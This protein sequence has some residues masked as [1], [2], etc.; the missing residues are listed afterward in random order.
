MSDTKIKQ[1]ARAHEK[2]V[3][4]SEAM[5][6]TMEVLCD[7][8]EDQIEG[9]APEGYQLANRAALQD[10]RNA[11]A[12]YVHLRDNCMFCGNTGY[13]EAMSM[14]WTEAQFDEFACPNC[15]E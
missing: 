15:G 13:T 7:I 14:Q 1:A 4:A 6:A 11:L 8:F 5:A 10:A 9:P 12:T 3:D 2:I